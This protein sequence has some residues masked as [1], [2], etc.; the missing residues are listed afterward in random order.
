MG[1]RAKGWRGSRTALSKIGE[2]GG[3]SLSGTDRPK[4]A[5]SRGRALEA[6]LGAFSGLSISY[7][8]DHQSLRFSHS[9]VREPRPTKLQTRPPASRS[10]LVIAPCRPYSLG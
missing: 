7:R 5:P 8:Q 10:E 4:Y 3:F 2:P 9:T 1:E 6:R